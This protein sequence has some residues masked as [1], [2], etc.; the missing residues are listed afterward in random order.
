VFFPVA[1][2]FLVAGVELAT[3]R[4]VM[5]GYLVLCVATF[6]ALVRYF[7]GWKVAA[8]ATLLF[9]FSPGVNLLRWGRQVLGEVPAMFFLLL[10]V[11]LWFKALQ[12]AR[13]WHRRGTLCL[14][15]V[16]LGLTILTKNQFLLLLPAWLVLWF[17]DRLYY[18]QAKHTH[19]LYPLV[20]AMLCVLAWYIA[21]RLFLPFGERLAEHNVQEWSGAMARGILSFSVRRLLD[22]LNFLTGEDA[23]YAWM[24][25]GALYA[26]LLGTR[27][28]QEGL[29]WGLLAVVT[30][31]W[32][33]WFVLVS[34]GWPR[35]AFPILTAGAIFTAQLLHDLTSG[36]HTP[37]RELVIGVRSGQLDLT[38]ARELALVALGVLIVLH[39]ASGRFI[40]VTRGGNDAAQQMAAYIRE[41]L[42]RDSEIETYEPEICFLSGYRCHFPPY[43]AFNL[44]VR[45][46]W[47]G[48]P[49]PSEYYD[50]G[51]T[52]TSH[53]LIGDFGQWVHIYDPDI[54]ARDYELQA[55]IGNYRLYRL[56]G[57]SGLDVP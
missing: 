12:E 54:V 16:L 49:P 27:R 17:L 2:A 7:R 30:V 6:Y 9:V 14:V 42:P 35:Y 41:H 4:V 40:E 39:L 24:L 34:V 37:F 36:L 32:L 20:A 38:R 23:F 45:Y 11:L 28:T 22:S 25:P 55:S 8:T 15:G 3:A 29:R 50:L 31:T 51:A 18:R 43:A 53:L 48:G 33:G 5:V 47:Y 19:F 46:V 52:G 44:A 13:P 26:L 1:S 10:G 56:E 57:D 21:Q